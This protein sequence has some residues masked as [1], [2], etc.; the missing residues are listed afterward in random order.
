MATDAIPVYLDLSTGN[1]S[2]PS[3]HLDNKNA[4]NRRRVAAKKDPLCH[5]MGV[6]LSRGTSCVDAEGP[7]RGEKDRLTL[8]QRNCLEGIFKQLGEG[9]VYKER[10]LDS[11][12]LVP[13]SQPVRMEDITSARTWARTHTV[14]VDGKAFSVR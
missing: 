6:D 14:Y 3:E 12:L 4:S 10:I 13:C 5:G 9:E 2:V 7:S 8:I 1:V 11:I